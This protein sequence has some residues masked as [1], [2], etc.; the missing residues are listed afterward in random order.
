MATNPHMNVCLI[1]GL[2]DGSVWIHPTMQETW[3]W[4]GRVGKIPWRR[5]WQPT[6]VFLPGESHAQRSLCCV[7]QSCLPLLLLIRF[8]RVRIWA[9]PETAA[10]QAPLSLGFSRR[11]PWSGLPFPSSRGALVEYSPWGHIESD[12]LS[13]WTVSSPRV[14][15]LAIMLQSWVNPW[16]TTTLNFLFLFIVVK[17]YN[18]KTYYLNHI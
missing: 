2:P 9:T 8:S 6:P 14:S 5:R 18:N 11:E 3:I 7:I 13:D 4:S 16:L 15:T 1:T 12:R 10:H 17:S